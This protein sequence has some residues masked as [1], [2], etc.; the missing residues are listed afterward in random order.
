MAFKI[1]NF[2]PVGGQ[3]RSG[4]APAHWSYQSDVD[5]LAT[6]LLADY[7]NELGTQVQPG[8]FIHASLLNGKGILTAGFTLISPPRVVIDPDTIGFNAPQV[9]AADSFSNLTTWHDAS[10]TDTVEE[11]DAA[12]RVK[13]WLDKSGNG[14]N[15]SQF[16]LANQP[17]T[18]ADTINAL[19]VFRFDGADHKM[20]KS[21]L[22]VARSITIF[23]V[24]RV[25]SVA[26]GRDS[27]LS[28]DSMHDFQIDGGQGVGTSIWLGQL[29]HLGSTF[30]NFPIG[31]SDLVGLD[32]IITARFSVSELSASLRIN[33][34]DVGVDTYV[35]P[36]LDV[37]EQY[38]V[39]ANRGEQ[40]KPEMLGA[41][42]IIYGRDFLP[43]EIVALETSLG[44]KWGIAL[45]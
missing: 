37:V 14:N 43:D 10:D 40:F 33:G 2:A 39:G 3:A 38:V 29:N 15:L 6:V 7:F 16:T 26:D 42:F 23:A 35:E 27:I 19:N 12:G 21:S 20:V 31:S 11:T 24:S 22:S 32:T 8:D 30:G 13:T 5:N 34:L 18:G 41:E 9:V 45:G 44:G 28:F 36:F 17:V 1:K 4:S 25:I